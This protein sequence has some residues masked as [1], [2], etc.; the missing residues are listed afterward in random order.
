MNIDY[1]TRNFLIVDDFGGFRSMLRGMLQ[2]L[3]AKNID[4][5]ADGARAIGKMARQKYDVI[6]CDY[7]LGDGQ[8]GQGV[9]EEAKCRG[10]VGYSTAFIM[11]TAENTMR[12]VMGAVE[13]K[14]DDYLTKPF[15]KGL[16]KKR[17][18]K[19]V[20]KKADLNRVL[21]SADQGDYMRAIKYCDKEIV[22]NPRAA[23]DI[24][25]IKGEICLKI[26]KYDLAEKIYQKVLSVKPLVWARLGMGKLFYLRGEYDESIEI[27]QDLI[28]ENKLLVE[29]YDLLALAMQAQGDN[30]KAQHILANAVELSPK[31]ITRQKTLGKIAYENKDLNAAEQA[32]KVSVKLGK[33]S[34][35]KSPDDH[36]FLGKVLL[37]Q[38]KADDALKLIL[39]TRKEF[40]RDDTVSIGTKILEAMAFKKKGSDEAGRR[41]FQDAC[42]EFS[43][44]MQALP[45]QIVA[46]MVDACEQF[47]EG[48]MSEVLHKALKGAKGEKIN[49]SSSGAMDSFEYLRM[50]MLGIELY[51]EGKVEE[52]ATLFEK[53]ATKLRTNISVNMNA[54]QTLLELTSASGKPEKAV[55][56]RI[57]RYLDQAKKIDSSNEKY[58]KLEVLYTQVVA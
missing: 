27:L 12:M 33:N 3:G 28:M 40:K 42:K 38:N 21:V 56:K 2:M 30:E 55:L 13:Y 54:A 4:D 50:N 23:L 22:E 29:A 46:D 17:L 19:V 26:K 43:N 11:I 44:G 14:P 53:S 6:L 25:K 31:A 20:G 32:L 48:E 5:A 47:G 52:A 57:R 1:G 10:L 34:Y 58:E 37:E 36:F 18:D 24:A 9:L 8:D 35:L 39:E 15:N 41:I 45:K 7:N 49:L 51:S 16:L